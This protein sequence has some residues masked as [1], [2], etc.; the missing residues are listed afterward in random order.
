V[1]V[2]VLMLRALLVRGLPGPSGLAGSWVG[3]TQ[4][5]SSLGRCLS[6]STLDVPAREVM[7]YDVCIVGA[8]PAGLSA[9]IKIKQLCKE[10]EKD[11]SVCVLEKG[12]SVGAH[13]LSGNVLE[14]RALDELLPDWKSDPD[15]PIKVAAS[16]DSFRL[17]TSPT[18]SL[19]LPT[20]KHMR[21]KGNYVVSLSEVVRWLAGKAEALG[22][23]I[24]PGFAASRLLLDGQGGVAGVATNDFGVGKSG[25]R[26]PTYQPGVDLR[27]KVTLL[28]EGA[29]GSLSEEAIKRY[30][31][32]AKGMEGVAADPQSYAL[33][34][35]E[36]WEVPEAV[37]KPGTVLHTL[38][39]PLDHSTYGGG[40]LYHMDNRRVALGLVVGLD[41]SNPY[42]SPYQEFQRWKQHPV[43]QEHI[44][45]GTC[46]QYGA[47]SL[48]E[49]G[50]QSI[51]K[52]SFPGGALIGCSAGL[53]NVPK[54]K[55]T[56]TAM[57]S[58][59]GAGTAAFRVLTGQEEP[60]K[61]KRTFPPAPPVTAAESDKSSQPVNL[62][63]YE[64]AIKAS[65]VWTELQGVRN[66]RPG[67][68]AGLYPGLAHAAIDQY[69]L[70]GKAWWT[71][72]THKPDHEHL[73][74]AAQSAPI[75]YPKP[76]GVTTFDIPTSLYRSGTNH[77]HDQP[78]HLRLKDAGVPEYMNHPHYAAPE[79]RYCPAGVYEYIKDD[80]G[81][82]KLQINAQNCLHCKACDIKDPSQNIKW[83]VPEGGGG[84]NYTVM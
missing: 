68:A 67:F 3:T 44:K 48:N 75:E 6:S 10:Q 62:E 49:G 53:L 23:D 39:Y 27:A 55:G 29:R 28:G 19:P 79:S 69:L 40:F 57:L 51:P 37:H 80:Q 36:V 74:P 22:V 32:R 58:G 8:G 71:L 52:L 38:G 41:Y 13:I 73:Q 25:A 64:R 83:T 65:W 12:A 61:P 60:E 4:F 70:R 11:V 1:D 47:R 56:H 43:V 21:N 78:P 30:N 66:V 77:D 14:P 84:P 2:F 18:S 26:K 81:R 54:I 7:Q 31:L 35:K 50:F 24:F 15:A 33:G 76:D 17:L 20:P 16:K 63:S 82:P 5:V 59:I 9:A 34:I 72:H 42:L 45:G 46:L